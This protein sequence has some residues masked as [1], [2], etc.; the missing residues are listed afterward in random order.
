MCKT[1][2]VRWRGRTC[3][4]VTDEVTLSQPLLRHYHH[5]VILSLRRILERQ[6][7]ILT[8][9]PQGNLTLVLASL[10]KRKLREACETVMNFSTL[11][12]LLNKV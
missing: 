6:P 2:S 1:L 12:F 11:G 10:P 4:T 9:P 5:I 7:V 8:K 3:E